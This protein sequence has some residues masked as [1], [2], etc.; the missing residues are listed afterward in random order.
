MINWYKQKYLFLI[1]VCFTFGSQNSLLAAQESGLN[2]IKSSET[3]VEQLPNKSLI[4]QNATCQAIN[5][6]YQKVYS[7]STDL[8]DISICQLGTNFYYHRQSKTDADNTLLIPATSALG[9]SVF[10]ATDGGTVYFSG[11]NGDRYYSSV[12]K[13]NSE[14]VFEPEIEPEAIA[15]KAEVSSKEDAKL[16]APSSVNADLNLDNPP[17]ISSRLICADRDS[18]LHPHL[19]GWQKLVGKSADSANQYAVS[20]GHSF[21]YNS[22]QPQMAAIETSAGE[23]IDLNIAPANDTIDRVCINPEIKE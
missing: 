4:A 8:H 10:Q 17:N 11:Q 12:M 7:F 14:I 18:A 5:S 1:A 3:R 2:L 13:N 23:V 16:S 9:G 15:V 6:A 21:I 19:D 22:N 20:Q